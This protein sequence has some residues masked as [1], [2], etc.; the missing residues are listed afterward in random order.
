MLDGLDAL[1]FDVQDAG[2]R[3]YTYISTMGYA[4]E[5]AAK[6]GIDFYVLDRPNPINASLVQGPVMDEDLKG[7]TGYFPLPVRH[8]MTVGELAGMFNVEGGIGAK[9]HVIP[10][11]G[12]SRSLWYDETGLQWVS[13]SP[14]LRSLT[15]EI[16]YP[17]VALVEGANVSVGRGTDTP[18]EVVGAP[19]INGRKLS[20]LS[21]QLRDCGSSIRANHV[22]AQDRSLQRNGMQRGK[23][24]ACRS[25]VLECRIPGHRPC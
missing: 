5:A 19:W 14:N 11:Q 2:T 10:M 4:M 3:F 6:K 7:F 20:R 15:E 16:L 9:L 13:P 12:Y 8:G 23:D 25:P 22:Y 18:F 1:V 21:E 17:G 24:H